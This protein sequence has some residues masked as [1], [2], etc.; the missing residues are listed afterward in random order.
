MNKISKIIWS[1]FSGVLCIVYKS[2]NADASYSAVSNNPCVAYTGGDCQ[3]PDWPN[4]S[5]PSTP[6]HCT[7]STLV[8]ARITGVSVIRES[9]CI[10]CQKGYTAVK[11]QKMFPSAGCSASSTSQQ[12]YHYSCECKCSNCPETDGTWTAKGTGYQQRTSQG[13]D[14][15]SGSAICKKTTHYRCAAGYYGSPTNGTFGC[16]P[17][18][19]PGTSVAGTVQLAQCYIP[20]GTYSDRTGKYVFNCDCPYNGKDSCGSSSSAA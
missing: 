2:E 16:T 19:T 13:C 17:C 7:N 8:C 10:A 20:K 15:S 11:G 3:G 18:P 12:Y 9:L 1:L 14:C 4:A 5:L 6:A